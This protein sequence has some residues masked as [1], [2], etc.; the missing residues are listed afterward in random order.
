MIEA[1]TE[2]ADRT[3]TFHRFYLSSARL[4]PERFAHAVRVHWRIENALH[5]V[6][7]TTFGEDRA[8]TCRDHGPDN[9]TIL[10]RLTLNLLQTNRPDISTRRKRKRS[11][12][13]N[14]F[15]GSILGQIR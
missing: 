10:R 3:A 1:S 11:G 12:W 7:D 8:R 6:L 15:A 5:W 14:D 2:T 4:T 13:S 9:L